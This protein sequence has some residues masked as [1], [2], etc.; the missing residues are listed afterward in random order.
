MASLDEVAAANAANYA[1]RA[2]SFARW[3]DGSQV[4]SAITAR[5]MFIRHLPPRHSTA[6]DPLRI[7]DLGCGNGRDLAV[8]AGSDRNRHMIKV[9]GIDACEAFCEMA[10]RR[11]PGARVVC[12]SM[13]DTTGLRGVLGLGEADGAPFH[14]VFSL[15]S[16]FHVPR[17]ALPALFADVFSLL[18]P[19]GIFFATFPSDEKA[20][21]HR[22]DDGRWHTSLPM[23]ELVALLVGAGFEVDA[24]AC[25][26]KALEMYNGTWDAVVARRAPPPSQH[27]PGTRLMHRDTSFDYSG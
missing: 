9:V 22:G 7:L 2:E 14:G 4:A 15:C 8:F 24:G 17:R 13:T 20:T 26:P 16:L 6:D 18:A 11:V 21:D 3:A 25:F 27:P 12:A 5:G 10:R 1:G 19:G 23:K